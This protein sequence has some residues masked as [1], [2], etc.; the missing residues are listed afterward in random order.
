MGAECGGRSGRARC[1]VQGGTADLGLMPKQLLRC[2]R[3]YPDLIS[4]KLFI[5]SFCLSQFPHESVK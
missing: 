1:G 4:Q 3:W 5:K 2:C